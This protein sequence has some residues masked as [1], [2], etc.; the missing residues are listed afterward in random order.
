MISRSDGSS[1]I[2]S[3]LATGMPEFACRFTACQE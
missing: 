3:S 1:G 2:A